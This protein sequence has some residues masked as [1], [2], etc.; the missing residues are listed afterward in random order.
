MSFLKNYYF[1]F[2]SVFFLVFS[3]QAQTIDSAATIVVT[4]NGKIK[5]LL[6]NNT[7]VW[8]GIR[9]AKAP[10][11]SLRFKAPQPVENWEGIK[12]AT[13]FG[14]IA[15]QQ[16]STKWKKNIHEDCLFLNIWVA[17][18]AAKKRPVMFWIHGGGFYTGSG[19]HQIYDGASLAEKGDVVVVTINYRLGPLGFLYFDQLKGNNTGFENNLGIKD[20]IAAL[21]WVKDNIENFGGDPEN[22][23]VFGQS[24]GATSVL[25]LMSIPSAKGLFQK[26]IAQS[27]AINQ[28]WTPEEATALTKNYMNLFG[29]TEDNISELYKI[30][31]DSLVLTANRMIEHPPFE[32]PGIGTFAPTIDGVFIATTFND[33]VARAQSRQIPLLIGT[34][35]HEMN[36]FLK[37]PITPFEAKPEDVHKLFAAT[38]CSEDEARVTSFYKH[39]P[40]KQSVLN[41][42]TDRVFRIPSISLADDHS[43]NISTYMYRF[44]WNSLPLNL[45][46]YKACHALELFFVF[47]TFNTRYGKQVTML[48]NK[49]K[50]YRISNKIQEAWINFAKTGNP[51]AIGSEKW[52]PYN[53]RERATMIFDRKSKLKFDPDRKHRLAW[54]GLELY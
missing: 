7:L 44:D 3:I 17:N 24:A 5:G 41:I 43:K 32:V 13:E 15:P 6:E 27:P 22:I 21:Q 28:N 49:R 48:A 37:I 18:T 51:N 11:D 19:S 2:I 20:Q 39:Y 38:D 45:T 50:A 9:Y 29:I 36:V 4:K 26:A 52:K 42:C 31:A 46:G 8:K 40:S 14:T 12:S 10:V 53:S 34:N 23:T 35:K 54:K 47:N 1:T 25:T 30:S 16:K 33:S